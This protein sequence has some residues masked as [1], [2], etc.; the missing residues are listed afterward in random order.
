MNLRTCLLWETFPLHKT[1]FTGMHVRV[2]SVQ[3]DWEVNF[4]LDTIFWWNGMFSTICLLYLQHVPCSKTRN[5]WFSF[6]KYKLTLTVFHVL[7]GSPGGCK[8]LTWP[9]LRWLSVFRACCLLVSFL[10]FFPRRLFLKLRVCSPELCFFSTTNRRP[11]GCFLHDK[12][13]E[14]CLA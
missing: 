12:L 5:F 13:C 11:Y 1:P 6:R 4:Y 3:S 8:G 10:G 7:W 9:W 2:Q 14:E